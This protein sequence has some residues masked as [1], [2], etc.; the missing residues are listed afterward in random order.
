MRTLGTFIATAIESNFL[1]FCHLVEIDFPSG[2]G[3]FTDFGRDLVYN[4][5]TYVNSLGLGQI[6]EVS[7][8]TLL[9]A[10]KIQMSISHVNTANIQKT[11]AEKYQ[12][13]PCNIYLAFFNSD[14][15]L[16]E[17]MPIFIGKNDDVNYTLGEDG[18]IT[19]N[20]VSELESWNRT[21]IRR[22]NNQDQ[23]SLYSGDKFFEYVE[24]IAQ[25]LQLSK[26]L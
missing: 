11:L 23:Q 12:G 1:K 16:Q 10:P 5:N 3:Y 20:A 14:E 15:V 7:E 13:R 2:V 9:E 6:S 21:K 4:G 25:G 18:Q 17:V 26:V 19:F 24:Q 22:Y 8:T